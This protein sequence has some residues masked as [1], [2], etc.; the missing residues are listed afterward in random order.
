VV[1]HFRPNVAQLHRAASLAIFARRA[2]RI[3]LFTEALSTFSA[4][5][6][7][8][9]TNRPQSTQASAGTIAVKSGTSTPPH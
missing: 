6:P 2:A 5:T 9:G 3:A 1:Q 4:L 8:R 7:V